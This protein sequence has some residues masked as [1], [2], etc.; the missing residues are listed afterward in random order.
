MAYGA[1]FQY[2][3]RT[4]DDRHHQYQYHNY[5]HGIRVGETVAGLTLSIARQ[6]RT[7]R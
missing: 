4:W 2:L 6:G 3:S 5:D 1:Y 7:G